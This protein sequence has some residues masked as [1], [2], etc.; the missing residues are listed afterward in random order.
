MEAPY[1]NNQ[2]LQQLLEVC[3]PSTHLCI[4]CNL[5]LS[6]EYIATK[7][8]K[9]WRNSPLPQLHKQNTVFILQ[10]NP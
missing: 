3:M 6:G 1:R 9:D 7:S 4:A 8:I 10:H 5:T 2:L